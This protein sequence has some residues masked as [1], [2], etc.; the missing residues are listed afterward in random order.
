MKACIL[1]KPAPIETNPLV[2]LDVPLPQQMVGR[3]LDV[4]ELLGAV[5]AG[6]RLQQFPPE[7]G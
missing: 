5:T 4:P 7:A 3:G 2:F 6:D 1:Q